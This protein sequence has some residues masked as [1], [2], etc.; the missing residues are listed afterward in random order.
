MHGDLI[1]TSKTQDNDCIDWLL[2]KRQEYCVAIIVKS[3]PNISLTLLCKML[4]EID[5]TMINASNK[6]ITNFTYHGE[7][8]L[9]I[10]LI[11]QI[12][13]GSILFEVGVDKNT[14]HIRKFLNKNLYQD[15]IS[16]DWKK[17]FLKHEVDTISN[18]IA[19]NK[20]D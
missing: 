20:L 2:L 19:K 12:V 6:P 4:F 8:H 1:S 3:L 18:V 11:E 9:P 15:I 5:K 7:Q 13:A 17:V 14:P 10:Q 16:G